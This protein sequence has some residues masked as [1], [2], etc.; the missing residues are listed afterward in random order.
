MHP[1]PG[2]DRRR[3]FGDG[4]SLSCPHA[5]S[6]GPCGPGA[7]G[8]PGAARQTSGN[9]LTA[10]ACWDGTA[11]TRGR[12]CSACSA[13]V[14]L[15]HFKFSCKTPRS[16]RSEQR[17]GIFGDNQNLLPLRPAGEAGGSLL[18]PCLSSEIK[19]HRPR[20]HVSFEVGCLRTHVLRVH[21]RASQGGL[22]HLLIC[23]LSGPH[24][25]SVHSM[26]I[27]AGPGST[28]RWPGDS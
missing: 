3:P 21:T 19:V 1:A 24:G 7:G 6:L 28:P 27:P 18:R 13:Y 11:R 25:S 14:Q 15:L 10:A 20:I 9:L 12:A 8:G 2:S 23:A 22:S 16:P 26:E 4:P 17:L 5:T